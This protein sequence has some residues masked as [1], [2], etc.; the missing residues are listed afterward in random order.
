MTPS[1][2]KT[3]RL[4]LSVANLRGIG[5]SLG[6]PL[7]LS[8]IIFMSGC[9]LVNPY[10][11]IDKDIYALETASEVCGLDS[12]AGIRRACAYRSEYLHRLGLDAS[13]RNVLGLT[14][15]PI[16]A[17]AVGLG[18]DGGNSTAITVLG[19]SGSTLYATGQVLTNRPRETVLLQGIKA[20]TCAITASYSVTLDKQSQNTLDADT[21]NKLANAL[22]ELRTANLDLRVQLSILPNNDQTKSALESYANQIDILSDSA[23][24]LGERATA[25]R[26][27][28][29]ARDTRL[30]LVADRINDAVNNSIRRTIIDLEGITAV[31]GGLMPNAALI[32]PTPTTEKLMVPPIKILSDKAW[33]HATDEDK[34]EV[35]RLIRLQSMQR[36]A[37]VKAVKDMQPALE[38][39]LGYTQQLQNVVSLF[40]EAD[41]SVDIEGCEYEVP[42]KV[43]QLQLLPSGDLSVP[44]KT[45]WSTALAIEGGSQPFAA[46]IIGSNSENITVTVAQRSVVINVAAAAKPGSYSILVR[47]KTG[48]TAVKQLTIT[49]EVKGNTQALN[50]GLEKWHTTKKLT[51]GLNLCAPDAAGILFMENG[52]FILYGKEEALEHDPLKRKSIHENLGLTGDAVD[53]KFGEGARKRICAW[54]KSKALDVQNG[55]LTEYQIGELGIS[56]DDANPFDS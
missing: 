22:G 36:Q 24:T 5:K 25:I 37:A 13:Y 27:W 4:L 1:S 6:L 16:G 19:L 34:K 48:Q 30:G 7:A 2:L 40:A 56:S 38:K 8:S 18:I 47:D 49:K 50:D 46:Q 20:I 42:D 12:R 41:L 29:A 9:A 21:V 35:P 54:Q 31:V 32:A 11:N 23:K 44:E 26:N 55:V 14:L 39:V 10:V 45:A 28:L 43:L 17:A 53:G 33:P 3:C 15:I 51:D 52:K